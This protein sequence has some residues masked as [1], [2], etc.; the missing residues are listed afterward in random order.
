MTEMAHGRI[1]IYAQD[2][3][4]PRWWRSVDTVSIGCVFALFAIGILLGF[5]ASPALA[6]RNGLD[7]FYYVI[8]QFGFGVISLSLMIVMS[9]MAPDTARRLGL[10]GFLCAF[11]AIVLLP[12]L[13]TDFGQGATRWYSLGFVSVQPSEFL[14]P[15]FAIFVAWLIAA[16]FDYQGPPGK[17]VT[18]V[19]MAILVLLLALQ[20]DFGQASLIVFTWGVIYFASGASMFFLWI[21]GGLVGLA[22]MFAY[23]N[24][25]HVA[26]RVDGFLSPDLTPFSQLA[27]ATDAIREGGF[28]GVGLGQGRVKSV[29]PD[30]HTDFI[31][32]VAAEEYGVAFVFLI[33]ALFAVIFIRSFFRL[34]NENDLFIRLAGTGLISLF[35]LQAFINLGVAVRVLPAKGM[36][37]PFKVRPKC[38]PLKMPTFYCGP[39][40]P[41][42]VTRKTRK[43]QFHDEE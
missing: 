42:I 16:S 4:L 19:T 14:K 39:A 36:T 27:Y 21:V 31:I 37:L 40:L 28:F 11:V 38:I 20:P 12:F 35:A 25:Q 1:E 43:R 18:F 13:G 26:R 15:V 10:V 6:Q 30:A 2:P 3:V 41:V 33:M 7:P 23:Q 8:R 22:G 34:M 5:A 32:A 17:M 9:M 24:S 29:L